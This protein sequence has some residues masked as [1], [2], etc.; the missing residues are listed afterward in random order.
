[1]KAILYTQYGEPEVLH[2]GEYEKPSPQDHELLIRVMAA[3]ATKSD[4]ELRSFQFAV[5]W[6]WLPLRVILGLNKP[7]NPILGGYFAGEVAAIGKDVKTLEVGDKIYGSAGF[8]M[9][10]Y[11]EFLALSEASTIGL[12]PG[13]LSFEEAAIVP[14]GGLNALHYMRRAKIQPGERVLINGAGASIGTN[15]VQIAKAMGAEVTAVDSGIKEAKLRDLGADHFIDYTQEDFSQLDERYDV[16]FNMVAGASYSG[17]IRCLTP[18]GRYLMANP[19]V[20]DMLRSA[21][22]TKF[23]DKEVL[24]AFAGEKK[25]ELS[26]LKQ[27]IEAGQIRPL[28]D[29]TYTM[30]EAPEA[31]HRVETE[32][33]IGSAVISLR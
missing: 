27:M 2:V 5:S 31:H 15:A 24:F 21:I 11:G 9:G 16:I 14:L 3:E 32:Q 25:E 23:T 29:K 20:S 12:M 28:L 26:A 1:M 17:C 7:K 33:R 8:T 19:R 30:A 4:C 18:R 22:S 6:F 13:N 10:A